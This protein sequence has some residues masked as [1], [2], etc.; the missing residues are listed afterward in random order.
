MPCACCFIDVDL[1]GLYGCVVVCCVGLLGSCLFWLLLVVAWC[2][3]WWYCGL[4]IS[5]LATVCGFVLCILI[6]F[7]L[8]SCGLACVGVVCWIWWVCGCLGCCFDMI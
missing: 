1:V 6:V 7:D 2:R 4:L 3:L 5:W 8:R